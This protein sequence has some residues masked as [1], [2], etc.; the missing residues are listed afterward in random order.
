M[1]AHRRVWTENFG[2]IPIDSEGRTYEVHHI[3]GNNS[4]NSLENL[5]A[6]PIRLHYL[7][8]LEQGD[9]YAANLIAQRMG[10]LE[11]SNGFTGKALTDEHKKAVGDAQRGKPKSQETK[12]KIRES[13]K[14]RKVSEETIQKRI[15]VRTGKKHKPISEKR[16]KVLENVANMQRGVPKPKVSIALKG[17]K[18]SKETCH[19]KG[20]PILVD[21]VFFPTM[22][23]AE[24]ILGKSRH[25][26][27]NHH[28]V[29]KI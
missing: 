26:I 15:K 10:S 2:E 25:K 12:D 16:K 5:I 7:L 8:H 28:K 3:D 6:L 13:L 21:G 19:K 29:E 23:E 17:K 27:M 22:V 24:K 18:Q 1:N 14:G 11:Y 4:N 20:I 9:F